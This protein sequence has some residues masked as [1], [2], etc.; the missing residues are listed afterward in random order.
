MTLS[1]IV[2]TS[3]DAAFFDFAKGTILSLREQMPADQRITLGFLDAGCTPA[4]LEWIARHV[5]VIRTPAWHF[6]FAAA[7]N[8]PEFLKALLAR[9]FLRDY[10][11]G[12]DVYAWIDADAWVQ[13]FY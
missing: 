10:F 12:F 1:A 9:P 13:D 8:A 5:D 3:A 4:Q 6:D 2:I 7:G 11:P